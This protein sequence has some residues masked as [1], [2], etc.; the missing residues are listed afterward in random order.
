MQDAVTTPCNIHCIS[1]PT[2]FPVGDVNVFIVESDR[3]TLIDA[4]VKTEDAW[5]YFVEGLEKIGY[6]PDDIEQVVL[7][8]HHPDHVGM[9]DY[10]NENIPVF[11]HRYNRPWLIRD[12]LFFEKHD[13]FFEKLF[14]NLGLD[15]QFI[16][17]VPNSK[18]RW[19][20]AVTG[21]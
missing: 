16:Q 19:H 13:Q 2:P 18:I 17:K 15:E 5:Q 12:P 8:H 6:S 7:T 4:G 1:L 3:L 20:L 21:S 14:R 9:L 11:G 10:L